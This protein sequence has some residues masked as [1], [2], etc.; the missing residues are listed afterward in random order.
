METLPRSAQPA[1][2]AAVIDARHQLGGTKLDPD[3]IIDAQLRRVEEQLHAIVETMAEGVLIY[4]TEGRITFVNS[5]AQRMLKRPRRSL[6]GRDRRGARIRPHHLDGRPMRD[7]ESLFAR[8]TASREPIIGEHWRLLRPDRTFL[9]V[10]INAAP[11]YDAAGAL[12][13]V[14]LTMFDT[15]DHRRAESALREAED[16]LRAI[17]G[18]TFDAIVAL[19]TDGRITDFNGAAERLFGRSRAEV[20]GQPVQLLMPQR[21]RGAYTAAFQRRQ[22][23][24]AKSFSK[25]YETIAMRGNGTELTVEISVTG[26]TQRG[27]SIYFASF[28][29]TR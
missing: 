10:T 28:R 8:L 11:V 6:I 29:E 2:V 18:S 4:D 9:D 5:T 3:P 7:E 25:R 14:V 12:T 17:V 15:T 22:A 24:P 26:L 16:R 27:R 20:I 19:D 23:A 21:L 1:L 13:A